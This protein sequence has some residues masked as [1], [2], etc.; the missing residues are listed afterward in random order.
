MANRN[1]A[2]KLSKRQNGQSQYITT[3]APFQNLKDLPVPLTESQCVLHKHEIL[4]C[5]GEFKRYCYSYHILKNE[6]KFICEYPNDVILDGHCVVKLM[7]NNNKDNNEITL[8]SFGGYQYRHTLVMKYASVWSNDNEMNKSK[9][10]EKLSNYNEWVPLTNDNNNPFHIG[11]NGDYYNGV[12]TLIGGS[13]NHLLFITYRP[14]N[15]SVFDLNT[16]QFIKHDTLPTRNGISF[17][18][19]VSKS[20][21]VKMNEAKNKKIMKCCYFVVD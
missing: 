10:L 17:H 7:D 12:R 8:L 11:R 15:I 4:I 16:F 1:T 14:H 19:F 18:C 3:S 21:M 9:K 20:K 13:N 5:G 6:Y 2:Q